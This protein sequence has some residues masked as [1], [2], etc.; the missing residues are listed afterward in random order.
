MQ[1]EAVVTYSLEFMAH[2]V[3]CSSFKKKKKKFTQKHHREFSSPT[4]GI[5]QRIYNAAKR[6]GSTESHT[7]LGL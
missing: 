5:E 1:H 4:C 6:E 7:V 2:A 3:A